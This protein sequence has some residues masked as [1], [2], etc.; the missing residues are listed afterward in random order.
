[1]AYI[2]TINGNPLAV[3]SFVTP[4]QFGAVGDGV[5]DDTAAIQAAINSG[6]ARVS[7][8]GTGYRVGGRLSFRSNVRLSGEKGTT[9]AWDTID[10]DSALMSGQNL[11]DIVIEGIAFDFGTQSVLRYGIS[12][13][14]SYNITV[15]N[16]SFTGGYGYAW[17][18]NNDYNVLFENCAFNAI[19][20]A[21]GNPGGGVFGSDFHDVTFDGCTCDTIGDHMVYVAG[22]TE[23]YNVYV[24]GCTC[25]KTGQ[26]GLTNG[27]AVCVYANAHD[28]IISG[29]IMKQCRTGVYVG[30]YGEYTTVPRNVTITD[31]VVLNAYSNGIHLVGIKNGAAVTHSHVANNTIYY[32][33]Q[34]GIRFDFVTFSTCDS[35]VISYPTRYGI[36]IEYAAYCTFTGGLIADVRNTALMVGTGTSACIYCKFENIIMTQLSGASGTNGLYSRQANWCEYVNI[37]AYNFST[38]YVYGGGAYNTYINTQDRDATKSIY[39]TTDITRADLHN[40]GDVVLNAAPT[41]GQPVMWVCTAAGSPGTMTPV[42]TVP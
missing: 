31:N 16:C 24:K 4:E 23:A 5:T 41:S 3:D 36:A 37:K 9:L 18:I 32:C 14:D 35:N 26:N 10:G 30:K 22:V 33:S 7:F 6:N 25:V 42:V 40:V 20:G 27:A 19:T 39:F 28:V 38:N 11:H 21:T 2:E 13:I 8:K 17:R 1:M 34:D 15:S 12:L 29:N